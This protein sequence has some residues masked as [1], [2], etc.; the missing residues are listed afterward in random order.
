M[1]EMTETTGKRTFF[2]SL[3]IKLLVGFTLI[4]TAVF[5]VAFYWF[6]DFSTQLALQRITDDLVNTLE[7]TVKLIDGDQL[8]ALYTETTPDADG[9]TQD[10]RYWEQAKILWS[11]KQVEPR[12]GIYTYI[13]GDKPNELIFITSGGALNDPRTGAGFLEHY[14]TDNPGPNV[15]GLKEVTLQDSPEGVPTD[16]CTYGNPGCKVV[17]YGDKF[18]RFVSAFAPIK[19]SKGEVV[20][21]LGVDFKADYVDEVRQKILDKVVVAFAITYAVLFVLVYLVSGVFT[22]PILLLTRAAEKIGE[23]DYEKGLEYLKSHQN[24]SA[25]PDEIQTLDRVFDGMVDKVYKREQM[26]SQQVKELKIEIDQTKRQKQVGEIVE[27]EFFQELHAKAQLMRK[28]QTDSDGDK[29]KE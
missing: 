22:Q 29:K 4:F 14:T 16:G 12:A 21:G 5:A 18:G 15:S 9:Y 27:S 13:L 28:K 7:G 26:L 6:Y 1:C 23:G 10:P 25:F 11:A 24:K 8:Q 19:N 3:R 17:A 2:V 20:A